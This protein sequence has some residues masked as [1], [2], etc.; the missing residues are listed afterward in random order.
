MRDYGLNHEAELLPRSYGGN[1]WL[2]KFHP[3][4][5]KELLSSLPVI[6]T[7]VLRGKLDPRRALLGHKLPKRDLQAVQRIY[8]QVEERTPRYELNLFITG[9]DEDVTQP[10]P[11]SDGA[12]AREGGASR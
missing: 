10:S 1:S 6:L 9:Y 12:E 4:A 8:E 11:A 5:T 2:G 3:A 7:G